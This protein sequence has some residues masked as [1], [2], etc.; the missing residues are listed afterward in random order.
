M[1]TVLLWIV[2]CGI[3][4]RC[5]VGFARLV[6]SLC[7]AVWL[8]WQNTRHMRETVRWKTRCNFG[9]CEMSDRWNQ[10]SD[11]K[12]LL[13][14]REFN[15]ICNRSPR[16][17][18]NQWLSLCV[19]IIS[20]QIVWTQYDRMVICQT[21]VLDSVFLCAMIIVILFGGIMKNKN[22]KIWI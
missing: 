18:Y 9:C 11:P 13:C 1:R 8:S 3:W 10:T 16:K 4:D 15:T 2:H 6:S 19:N 21:H 5:I 17:S 12:L 14:D 7:Q 22:E 20:K